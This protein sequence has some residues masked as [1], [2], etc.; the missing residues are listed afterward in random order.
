MFMY[1]NGQLVD[2][3]EAKISPFDHG[4]LYGVGV[5]E[6]IRTYG[7]IPFL[8]EEHMERLNDSLKELQI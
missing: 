4:Y 1:V 2:Q 7:G 8:L 6:T 5:F 3:S